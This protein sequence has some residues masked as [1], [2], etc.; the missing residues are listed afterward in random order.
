MRRLLMISPHFPPDSSAATHRVRLLAPHL[1]AC[2]WEP[3]VLTV[4]PE[5]YEGRLDHD[6]GAL[7][8]ESIRVVRVQAWPA[9]VTRLVR[10]GDLGLRSWAALRRAAIELC[11][12]ERFDAL[13]ITIYPTYPATLGPM[14]KRRFKL[15]FIL[16]YQD[17]WVS[18]W[19]QSVGPNGSAD[20]KSRLS[21]AVSRRLEP[22]ALFAADAVTAVSART[23][24]EALERNGCQIDV[25]EEIPIGWDAGD[26]RALE[27][28]GPSAIVPTSDGLLHISYVGTLLPA[29]VGVLRSVLTALRTLDDRCPDLGRRVRLHFVGT[30]NQSTGGVERVMPHARELGV[31]DRV[32]EHAARVDYLEALSILRQS[33][34][35]LLI[36]STEPHYTPSKAFPALMAGRP[37]LALYHEA[38][39]IVSLLKAA[40]PGADVVAFRVEDLTTPAFV[41]RVA[42]GLLNVARTDARAL[43][44]NAA[45][46]E[47][48]SARSLARRLARVCDEVAA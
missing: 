30:S 11:E 37:M 47:P 3:T 31:A 40:S 21:L 28:R 1:P 12:N 29:G 48:W 24:E 4:Q 14:L 45:A 9:Q 41:T 23:Y 43:P 5:A 36:G 39:P 27:S 18:A 42:D 20:L 15:P 46:L 19:G 16:D 13:F 22:R 44:V 17:P 2:G 32:V 8:P 6:L 38:S 34:A 26:V 33:S 25:R 35:V 10:V 7:V